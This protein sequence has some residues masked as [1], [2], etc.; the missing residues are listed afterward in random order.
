MDWYTIYKAAK[1]RQREYEILAMN[2]HLMRAARPV[3]RTGWKNRYRNALHNL[4]KFL[5]TWG[6]H[7]QKR[8]QT[9]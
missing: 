2:L 1:A 6:R 3:K 4:G 9:C 5:E 8:F 7:L